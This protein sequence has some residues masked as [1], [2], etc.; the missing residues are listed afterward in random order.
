MHFLTMFCKCLFI[1]IINEFSPLKYP[2]SQYNYYFWCV[3]TMHF[4][5]KCEEC[6]NFFVTNTYYNE[7]INREVRLVY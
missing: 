7:E 2:T 1:N 6:V 5:S 4:S 3:F